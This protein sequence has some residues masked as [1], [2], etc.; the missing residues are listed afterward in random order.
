MADYDDIDQEYD[1][2]DIDATV[3]ALR[4]AWKCMPDM[5]LSELLDTVTPLPFVEMT[6]S[7]LIETLNEFIHQSCQKL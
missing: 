1:P 4:E 2:V 3:E 6:N 7:E 5:S